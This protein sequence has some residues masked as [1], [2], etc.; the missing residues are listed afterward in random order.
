LEGENPFDL[1]KIRSFLFVAGKFEEVIIKTPA[2][3]PFSRKMKIENSC[4]TCNFYPKYEKLEEPL[5]HNILWKIREYGE[6]NLTSLYSAIFNSV[7][8]CGISGEKIPPDEYHKKRKSINVWDAQKVVIIT[9]SEHFSK[10]KTKNNKL[11]GH[12]DISLKIE[13]FHNGKKKELWKTFFTR[14]ELRCFK[15]GKDISHLL[16]RRMKCF[17]ERFTESLDKHHK[18]S[19]NF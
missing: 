6:F 10:G 17:T 5:S 7:S 13:E 8:I 15:E 19:K 9:T 3:L 2:R 4:S 11:I 12:G 1:E 16:P 18:H 14:E